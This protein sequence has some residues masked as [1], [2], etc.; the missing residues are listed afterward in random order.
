MVLACARFRRQPT[1][2]RVGAMTVKVDLELTE[3]QLQIRGRPEQRAVETFAA[4]RADQAFDKWMRQ[5]HLRHRLDGCH[6]EDSQIRLP[7]VESVQRIMVGAEVSRRRLA[8][9][10]SIEH[11]APGHAIHDAAVHAEAHDAPGTVVHHNQ[12]PMGAQ[13]RRFAPKQIKTPQTV[14]RVNQAP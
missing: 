3:F 2:H 12:R 7:L 6:V 13:C 1:Q 11:L 14:F 5:R 8:T 9:N 4:D 10:R